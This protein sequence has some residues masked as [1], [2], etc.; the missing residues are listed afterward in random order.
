MLEEL[1]QHYLTSEQLKA[2]LL[3][4]GQYTMQTLPPDAVLDELVGSLKSKINVW[5]GFN[6]LPQERHTRR[7]SQHNGCLVLPHYPVIRILEIKASLPGYLPSGDLNAPREQMLS[8][9]AV[10]IGQNSI[11]TPYEKTYYDV[12]YI[13]G[14]DPLPE[15]LEGLS[16]AIFAIAF[17][18]LQKGGLAFL[19]EQVGY[20]TSVSMRNLSQSIIFPGAAEAAKAQPGGQTELDKLL[21]PFAQFRRRLRY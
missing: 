10:P 11:Q 16:D 7:R 2:K 3:I 9:Y 13:S 18:A 8:V 4:S 6:L 19:G 12:S 20:L 17:L 14:Y 1:P 15:G 5:F 21:A